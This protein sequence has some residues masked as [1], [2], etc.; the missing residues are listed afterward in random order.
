M[1]QPQNRP[2]Q[3]PI[4]EQET[5]AWEMASE[6]RS[7]RYIAAQL[8]VSVGTAHARLKAAI[9]SIPVEERAELRTVLKAQHQWAIDMLREQMDQGRDPL[10]VLPEIRA[11]AKE[12]RKLCGLDEAVQFEGNVA[13]TVQATLEIAELV[14]QAERDAE[15]RVDELRREAS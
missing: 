10:E 13:A 7:V 1:T 6:G 9:A 12:L 11:W 14:E 3:A 2:N 15:A 4:A 8:G 5:R